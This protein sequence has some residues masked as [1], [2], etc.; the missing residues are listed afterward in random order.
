VVELEAGSVVKIEVG[1]TDVSGSAATDSAVQPL[2]QQ[3][4]V[5]QETALR[6]PDQRPGLRIFKENQKL[7]IPLYQDGEMETLRASRPGVPLWN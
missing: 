6:T 4:P 2:V 1:S 5:V 7:Y 3:Q